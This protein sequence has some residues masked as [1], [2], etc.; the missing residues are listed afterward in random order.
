MANPALR[1]QLL[2]MLKHR[3]KPLSSTEISRDLGGEIPQR[4]LRR[5]LSEWVAAGVLTR[6]G[7]GRAIRYQFVG[8]IENSYPTAPD[9]LTFLSGLDAD[10]K[11]S[12]LNQLRDLWTH[13]STALEGNILSLGDT[14][15]ILEEG[16][17]ISGKPIKDHQEVIGHARAIELLYQCLNE[18]LS[19]SI[20]T[21]LHQAVQT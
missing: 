2:S 12:L 3:S 8:K 19:E 14:H 1:R 6:L 18:P 7:N 10:L 21:S 17:T 13:T 4:T 11:I 20:V 9:S 16:L 15:F 5:W